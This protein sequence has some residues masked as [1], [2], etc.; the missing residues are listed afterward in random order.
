MQQGTL[1]AVGVL[2][3]TFIVRSLLVP[4]VALEIGQRMWWPAK[5]AQ[6]SQSG[7]AEEHTA[8]LNSPF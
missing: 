7:S 6:T 4:A 2:L 8:P 3:D 5:L 1:V